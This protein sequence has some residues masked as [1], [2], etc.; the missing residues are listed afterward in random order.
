[1]NR[2]IIVVMVVPIFMM[3][4]YLFKR[5]DISNSDVVRDTIIAFVGT[6]VGVYL[7]LYTTDMQTT[8]YNRN[9]LIGLL[10]TI[11]MSNQQQ[12]DYKI[13]SIENSLV[14]M[15]D[16]EGVVTLSEVDP[17]L[18]FVYEV[19]YYNSYIDAVIE[20]TESLNMI[21]P[22]LLRDLL[23]VNQ[24]LQIDIDHWNTLRA[25]INDLERIK[26]G[27]TYQNVLLSLIT[28]DLEKPYSDEEILILTTDAYNRYS[29]MLNYLAIKA[30]EN[31]EILLD[32]S[33]FSEM[34]IELVGQ[35]AYVVYKGER[36]K[37]T[38]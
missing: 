23:I 24:M 17:N 34:T 4:L 38:Q 2:E 1:M 16:D 13:A 32:A 21:D 10:E 3:Y 9:K 25:S 15:M 19:K 22:M 27:I 35:D 18:Q 26:F 5:K 6:L 37:V 14:T 29:G 7:A 8:E 30:T 28:S 11:Q 33:A 31:E 12:I 20:T 36:I